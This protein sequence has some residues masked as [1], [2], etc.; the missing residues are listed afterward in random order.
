MIADAA[1]R[2]PSFNDLYH[3]LVAA[4][5]RWLIG[6]VVAAYAAANLLF[7][8]LYLAGGDCIENARP[9]SFAD[10]F[11]FSVQTMATIGYGKLIPRTAYA[12]SLVTLEALIGMLFV[13]MS[14][15]LIFS[16]FA[17]PAARVLFSNVA[18]VTPRDGVPTLQF[19][20]ANERANQIVEAQVR[21]MLT[22]DEVTREGE[23]LRRFYDLPLARDRNAI[24][25]LTWTAMHAIT[26][27]SL[28]HGET[29]ES[30]AASKT[31]F[32][33]SL[34]GTDETIAQTIHARWS[35]LPAEIVWNARFADILTVLPDG[36][37]LVDYARFHDTVP[38]APRA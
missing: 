17:R 23:T 34:V 4:P 18:V 8:L 20:M 6:L 14:T 21:L 13:A 29:A 2:R 7:A 27:D 1:A 19:R 24:F 28:L 12:N 3:F 25:A 38:V 30:L 15:G 35:Y 37:R 31:E 36:R 33:V 22:R 10:A 11:F 5:W 32:V 26:P 16:K 9:G